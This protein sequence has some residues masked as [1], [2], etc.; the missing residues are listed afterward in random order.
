MRTKVGMHLLAGPPSTWR[1]AGTGKRGYVVYGDYWYLGAGRYEASALLSST[2][3][4]RVQVFNAA[5]GQLL[6]QRRLVATN[7]KQSVAVPFVQSDPHR[8][9]V[10]S[11]KSIFR[12]KPL[13][14]PRGQQIEVR[15]FNPGGSLVNVYRVGVRPSHSSA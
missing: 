1:I 5:T 9:P 2:G 6:G 4:V 13:P 7:G 10:F 14:P 8:D 15:V 12:I 11:G 3:P